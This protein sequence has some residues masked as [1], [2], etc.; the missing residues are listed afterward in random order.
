MP[1]DS[2]LHAMQDNSYS[3]LTDEGTEAQKDFS[4]LFKDTLPVR[5]RAG[6]GTEVLLSSKF[7]V[8]NSSLY[9]FRHECWKDQGP[10]S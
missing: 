1:V 3:H 2:V 4:S 7:K 9:C 10:G 8:L 5:G 6:V